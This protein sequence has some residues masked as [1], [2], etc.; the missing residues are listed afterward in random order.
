LNYGFL[1]LDRYIAFQTKSSSVTKI[2]SIDKY[3]FVA[4]RHV[5]QGV[6]F[7]ENKRSK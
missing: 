3:V 1:F 4:K 2:N 5:N 7:V 6:T